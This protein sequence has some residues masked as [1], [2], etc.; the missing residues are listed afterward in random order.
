LSAGAYAGKPVFVLASER[1]V[2][3]GEALAFHMQNLGLGALVGETT[4]GAANITNIVPLDHGFQIAVPYARGEGTTWEG[5]GVT[6]DIG[7]P[8]DDALKLALERLGQAPAPAPSTPSRR[9][10]C[11]PR[12]RRQPRARRPRCGG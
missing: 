11:F 8:G 2:S 3:A 6:P 7:G 12:A 9:N 5:L 10:A 4:A 1:T